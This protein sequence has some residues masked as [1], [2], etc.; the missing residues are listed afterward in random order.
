MPRSC[1]PVVERERALTA[2]MERFLDKAPKERKRIRGPKQVG[3][4]PMFRTAQP[5]IT[6][7]PTSLLLSRYPLA[8]SFFLSYSLFPLFLANSFP[9][10]S[11]RETLH[12]Q[13][14]LTDF[15]KRSCT[16]QDRNRRGFQTRIPLSPT[17]PNSNSNRRRRRI[18]SMWPTKRTSRRPTR[19]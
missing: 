7:L 16:R 4:R 19:R 12:D 5:C 9:L 2:E 11:C 13:Y 14:S 6:H 15:E 8:L 18:Q 17:F 1:F 3:E 10:L